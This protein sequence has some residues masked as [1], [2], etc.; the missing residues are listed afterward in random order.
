MMMNNIEY[1]DII[2]EVVLR[3]IYG[4]T[5]LL[6]KCDNLDIIKILVAVN[7]LNLQELI[8]HLQSFFNSWSS[9]IAENI[10]GKQSMMGIVDHS[11]KMYLWSGFNGTN[12]LNVMYIFDTIKLIG[13]VGS[14]VDAPTPRFNYGGCNFEIWETPLDQIT[15]GKVPSSRNSFS[16]I[17][18][19]YLYLIEYFNN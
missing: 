6:E 7:E 2:I 8:Y 5:L 13:R 4:G 15:L 9:K 10:Y 3:Y 11:G 17:L 14:S 1:Y 18:G 19:M 16:A 12:S